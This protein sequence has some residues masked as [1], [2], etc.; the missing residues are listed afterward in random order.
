[1]KLKFNKS[2]QTDDRNSDKAN[3]FITDIKVVSGFQQQQKED[4]KPSSADILVTASG[5][6]AYESA[7]EERNN[8]LSITSREKIQDKLYPSDRD[9]LAKSVQRTR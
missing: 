9:K 5:N 4:I 3:V 2:F 6:P 7:G 1:M 8:Q